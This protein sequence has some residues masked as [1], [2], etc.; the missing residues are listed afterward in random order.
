[1]SGIDVNIAESRTAN[2]RLLPIKNNVNGV[3]NQLIHLQTTIDAR[4]LNQNNLRTRMNN[5]R[6]NV[7]L[8][9]SDIQ[10]LHASIA[11]IL[12]RY[13]KTDQDLL[14]KVP[15]RGLMGNSNTSRSQSRFDD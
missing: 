14:S 11:S 9:E 1:M 10:R 15:T 2:A 7:A 8:I 6:S 5:A 12:N 13:E 3:V 4:I